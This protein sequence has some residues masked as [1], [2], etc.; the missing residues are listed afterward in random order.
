MCCYW[1]YAL[2]NFIVVLSNLNPMLWDDGK[3]F[4]RS[5]ANQMCVRYCKPIVSFYF[6]WPLSNKDCHFFLLVVE[7]RSQT[8]GLSSSNLMLGRASACVA[9]SSLGWAVTQKAHA[10]LLW[11]FI[12]A[13]WIREEYRGRTCMQPSHYCA[14]VLKYILVLFFKRI[15]LTFLCVKGLTESVAVEE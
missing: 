12:T 10:C 6:A 11:I 14:P 8:H 9:N 5:V 4:A 13:L 1:Q 3:V 2:D 7:A 15:W